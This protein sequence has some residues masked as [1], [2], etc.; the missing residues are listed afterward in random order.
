M[1]YATV[2]FRVAAAATPGRTGPAAP[3]IGANPAAA[4]GGA[5][6]LEGV[7]ACM[8][9]AI[10]FINSLLHRL[11]C[12]VMHF[13]QQ[14]TQIQRATGLRIN[15]NV[16][17]SGRCRMRKT[18]FIPLFSKKGGWHDACEMVR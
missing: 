16:H 18:E 11:T 13:A 6:C 7:L 17:G 9:S 15:Y 5:R 1:Q 10:A 14:R 3:R 12:M 2:N 8:C 4:D